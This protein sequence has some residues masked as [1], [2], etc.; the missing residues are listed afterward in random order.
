[1][2]GKYVDTA[3]VSSQIDLTAE[4]SQLERLLLILG[5]LKNMVCANLAFAFLDDSHI[6]QVANTFNFEQKYFYY[7]DSIIN[8]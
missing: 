4:L 2:V 5:L 1:M 3:A 8:C 6:T 7:H